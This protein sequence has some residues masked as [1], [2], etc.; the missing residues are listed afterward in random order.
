LV[1]TCHRR[2][3]KHFSSPLLHTIATC[4][5]CCGEC[6]PPLLSLWPGAI[7]AAPST[8]QSHCHTHEI[9]NM[10]LLQL[11]RQSQYALLTS[12]VIVARCHRRC[13]RSTLLSSSG[14]L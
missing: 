1:A 5:C 2:W 4:C 10:L 7:G 8:C 3:S 14:P 11:L 12:P 13:S 6:Y 9:Q